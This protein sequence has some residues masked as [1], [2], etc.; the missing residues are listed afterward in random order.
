MTPTI[1]KKET[2]SI[3]ADADFGAME[4]NAREAADLL[5][6]LGHECRL[7]ILC[8]LVEG[9][10]TVSELNARVPLSQ[11]ALSQHLAK[12]RHQNLVA[13]RKDAQMVYYR[14]QSDK[15]EPVIAT[16]YELYCK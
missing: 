16:L 5:K 3:P 15:V 11:S 9:E 7:M 4:A 6:A 2:P 14:L 1:E 10:K 13:I 8:S 12:L